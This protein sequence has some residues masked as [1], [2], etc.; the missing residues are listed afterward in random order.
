MKISGYIAHL[1][2]LQKSV[3]DLEVKST[4]MG[5]DEALRKT[6]EREHIVRF[7]E[8]LLRRSTGGHIAINSD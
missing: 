3:S 1:Q 6:S 7:L 5:L 4:G 8:Q 2:R